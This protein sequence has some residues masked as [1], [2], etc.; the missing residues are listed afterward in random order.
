M[1]KVKKSI[2][3]FMIVA[4]VILTLG[5]YSSPAEATSVNQTGNEGNY[6]LELSFPNGITLNDYSLLVEDM[7]SPVREVRLTFQANGT[8][9]TYGTINLPPSTLEEKIEKAISEHG[10]LTGDQL[11]A[12]VVKD[13]VKIRLVGFQGTEEEMKK[14]LEHVEKKRKIHNLDSDN[15]RSKIIS[16]E[17]RE[18]LSRQLAEGEREDINQAE[19]HADDAFSPNVIHSGGFIVIWYTPDSSLFDLSLRHA[20]RGWLSPFFMAGLMQ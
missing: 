13:S 16:L 10:R 5:L 18:E 11:H 17:A 1:G 15:M 8:E 19:I 12:T 3:F 9:I 7:A 6:L 20:I 4:I 14:A 2:S